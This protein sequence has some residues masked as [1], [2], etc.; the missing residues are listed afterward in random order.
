MKRSK[1]V[2][3]TLMATSSVLVLSACEE[4]KRHD[5]ESYSSVEACKAA[6]VF[7]DEKC[8]IEFQK[9]LAT[10]RES[11]P[12]YA[13]Q[14]LCEQEFSS[15]NC[16]QNGRTGGSS[17]WTPFMA[18]YLVSNIIDS[19]RRYYYSTPYYRTSRNVYYTWDGA[20]LSN[21]YENGKL[22][23]SVS[24]KTVKAKPKPAKVMTRTSVVSRGG[25]GARS[26]SRASRGSF[27]RG[28]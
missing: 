6:D 3:L 28:G 21:R 2:K 4:E 7:S 27:S 9:A 17:F 8:E 19:N 11:A 20:P 26:S 24:D 16:Q 12:R 1:K 25:F 18:G 23:H 14:S 13:S 15:G 10:H 5:A 22:R